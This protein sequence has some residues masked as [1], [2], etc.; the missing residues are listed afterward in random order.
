MIFK[1]HELKILDIHLGD[2]F[3][4]TDKTDIIE[5]STLVDLSF[6]GCGYFLTIRN[7]CLPIE[8]SVFN[9]P[10]VNGMAGNIESS[11]IIFIE[12]RE[13]MIECF[14]FGVSVPD[15]YR[16]WDIAITDSQ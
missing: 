3:S 2:A 14:S 7:D 5:N 13:L 15:E 1:K 12:N 11:F 16:D 8:R 10:I 4:K 9:K 6:S